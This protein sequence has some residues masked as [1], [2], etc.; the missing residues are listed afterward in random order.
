M[1]LYE[2]K[3]DRSACTQTLYNSELKFNIRNKLNNNVTF[4]KKSGLKYA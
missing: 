2:M 3:K 4:S 1:Q